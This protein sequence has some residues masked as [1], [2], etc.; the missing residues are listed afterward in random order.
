MGQLWEQSRQLIFAGQSLVEC[1]ECPCGYACKCWVCAGKRAP[2][3][4]WVRIAN[5]PVD[6]PNACCD[7]WDGDFEVPYIPQLPLQPWHCDWCC[8]RPDPDHPEIPFREGSTVN[9]NLPCVGSQ[10][11][12]YVARGDY[13]ASYQCKI[14]QF[15]PTENSVYACG[16][17][18][19]DFEW[20]L[21]PLPDCGNLG[22]LD[23]VGPPYYWW[24]DKGQCDLR[25]ATCFVH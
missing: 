4:V 19:N 23:E 2:C 1:D 10:L 25:G 13:N 16:F 12:V 3:S 21:P 14:E 22:Y 7:G 18:G 15:C 17:W 9:E 11:F 5:I 6:Q 8:H 20:P 24:T